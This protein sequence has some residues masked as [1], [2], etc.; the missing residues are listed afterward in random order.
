MNHRIQ[1]PCEIS[2]STVIGDDTKIWA[3]TKVLPRVIIGKG[4]IISSFVE[5]GPDV[6]IGDKCKIQNNVSVYKGVTLEEGVFAAPHVF[7]QMSLILAL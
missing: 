5:I 7:L 6:I 2:D 4:C 1:Q 3:Y